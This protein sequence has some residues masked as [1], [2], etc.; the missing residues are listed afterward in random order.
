MED[1]KKEYLEKFELDESNILVADKN[2]L[3]SWIEQKIKEAK[4]EGF[5]AGCDFV[6]KQYKEGK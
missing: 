6:S 1:I 4:D 3:W 5:Q 2:E